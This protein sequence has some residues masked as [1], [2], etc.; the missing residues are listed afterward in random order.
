MK[1]YQATNKNPDYQKHT[2]AI[3][4]VYRFAGFPTKDT[5]PVTG[6]GQPGNI[7]EAF[8]GDSGRRHHEWALA[9]I[10]RYAGLSVENIVESIRCHQQTR[11][12][13]EVEFYTE[14]A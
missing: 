13:S 1:R 9:T 4:T 6:E 12:Y 2:N 7:R 14:A 11:Y 8:P 10:A 5:F 3:R